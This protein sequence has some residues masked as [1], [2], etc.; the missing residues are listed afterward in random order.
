MMRFAAMIGCMV[1]L[2][3]AQQCHP[4]RGGIRLGNA[5]RTLKSYL[6]LSP[7]PPTTNRE[8]SLAE[9]IPQIQRRFGAC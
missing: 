4:Y 5:M 8:G 2:T 7:P 3:L 6:F 1:D 9:F